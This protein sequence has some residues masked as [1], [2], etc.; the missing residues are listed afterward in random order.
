MRLGYN[1]EGEADSL[2]SSALDTMFASTK[3][4]KV[5]NK[6]GRMSMN[7][8]MAAGLDALRLEEEGEEMGGFGGANPLMASNPLMGG[9]GGKGIGGR[10]K[11]GKG[12]VG[13]TFAVKPGLPPPHKAGGLNVAVVD[14]ANAEQGRIKMLG[15]LDSLLHEDATNPGRSLSR[16][17]PTQRVPAPHS[18]GAPVFVNPNRDILLLFYKK[19]EPSRM[20]SVDSILKAWQTD[21]MP[22]KKALEKKYGAAPALLSQERI[23]KMERDMLDNHGGHNTMRQAHAASI[24]VDYGP[25]A[26][27]GFVDG[28]RHAVI[29]H[30]VAAAPGS[31]SI[32]KDAMSASSNAMPMS[33]KWEPA[34][35]TEAELEAVMRT[36]ILG[37]EG[38]TAGLCTS[39]AHQLPQLQQHVRVEARRKARYGADV[40]SEQKAENGA[41]EGGVDGPHATEQ[42]MI[43]TVRLWRAVQHYRTLFERPADETAQDRIDTAQHI[44]D[45]YMEHAH[46]RWLTS[47]QELAEAADITRRSPYWAESASHKRRHERE[48]R[49]QAKAGTN[50]HA[51][52]DPPPVPPLTL[53]DE[54]QVA[55]TQALVTSFHELLRRMAFDVIKPKR[56]AK[57]A[58]GQKANVAG[59]D[60]LITDNKS[61]GQQ[62]R[63]SFSGGLLAAGAQSMDPSAAVL[64]LQD[65]RTHNQKSYQLML[66][67]RLECSSTNPQ[68]LRLVFQH[69]KKYK[70]GA[71]A[72]DFTL[73]FTCS[74]ER[75]VFC[76]LANLLAPHVQVAEGGLKWEAPMHFMNEADPTAKEKALTAVRGPPPAAG[77]ATSKSKDQG[78]FDAPVKKA[79]GASQG[80][81]VYTVQIHSGGFLHS[82]CMIL[83]GATGLLM[84]E[85]EPA[86][87][88]T[89]HG[90]TQTDGYHVSKLRVSFSQTNSKKLS[91]WQSI[92][93]N[94][95]DVQRLVMAVFPNPKLRTHFGGCLRDMRSR[96]STGVGFGGMIRHSKIPHLPA[97]AAADLLS[98]QRTTLNQ[99]HVGD[100][101]L[102]IHCATWNVGDSSPPSN[103]P[104]K[105]KKK[106]KKKDKK[107]KKDKKDKKKR[108]Q[109][110]MMQ[111]MS[112]SM[113]SVHTSMST[114]SVSPGGGGTRSL[115]ALSTDSA[116]G[117]SAGGE[118]GDM[119]GDMQQPSVDSLNLGDGMLVEEEEGDE[120][121]SDDDDEDQ[122]PLASLGSMPTPT[123]ADLASQYGSSARQPAV[124]FADGSKSNSS[125]TLSM[126]SMASSASG[127]DTN[128]APKSP[129]S[130]WLPELQHDIYAIALQECPHKRAWVNALMT[131]LGASPTPEELKKKGSDWVPEYALLSSVSLTNPSEIHLVIIIRSSLLP[132]VS[133]L[134]TST[135]ATGIDVGLTTLG[136]KGSAG[137]GFVFDEST[138]LAFVCSHLAARATRLKQRA[139]NYADSVSGLRLGGAHNAGGSGGS[140]DFLHQFDHVFWMGD[141]NYRVDLGH[142][143]TESEFNQCLD[144]IHNKKAE[145][146]C[147]LLDHDQLRGEM[148]LQQAFP[149]ALGFREAPVVWPPTYRMMKG[150]DPHAYSQK[151]FQNPSYTD[152]VLWRSAASARMNVRHISATP[153]DENLEAYAFE[154]ERLRSVSEVARTRGVSNAAVAKKK[155]D[156]AAA[157]S[158]CAQFELNDSDHR[159]V[160]KSFGVTPQ[161]ALQLD[162]ADRQVLLL[163]EAHLSFSSV[164]LLMPR[165]LKEE[166]KR[167]KD[168]E[169][170]ESL[171]GLHRDERTRSK[172]NLESMKDAGIE[173]A[174][175]T[176]EAV[177]LSFMG[178]CQVEQALFSEVAPE[179]DP[180]AGRKAE[181]EDGL[182]ELIAQHAA[183]ESALVTEV[184]RMFAEP[185]PH[186]KV[187]QEEDGAIPEDEAMAAGGDSANAAVEQEQIPTEDEFVRQGIGY[188]ATGS[189]INVGTRSLLSFRHGR[190]VLLSETTDEDGQHEE[191]RMPIEGAGVALQLLGHAMPAD[192]L[193]ELLDEVLDAEVEA[194]ASRQQRAN[195]LS[196]IRM[197]A[198]KARISKLRRHKNGVRDRDERHFISY[199][200]FLTL[201]QRVAHGLRGVYNAAAVHPGHV[202]QTDELGNQVRFTDSKAV[203]ERVR[204][205][206]DMSKGDKEEVQA[207]RQS[208]RQGIQEHKQSRAEGGDSTLQVSYQ[209]QSLPV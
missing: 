172:S 75:S 98:A 24:D 2:P 187:E 162:A 56:G 5:G 119:H 71:P 148:E 129:L 125:S 208:F 154:E 51:H 76:L 26:E 10:G 153:E 59:T 186:E 25:A 67:L 194:E 203:M 128:A 174:A 160:S 144:L 53:F 173:K 7:I 159:P 32:K 151:K 19:H 49:L 21:I 152:R 39:F 61:G 199:E 102:R 109:G 132:R 38:E 1:S 33:R 48:E 8:S 146:V 107:G 69:Q 95:I 189:Y 177:A 87:G 20:A 99:N 200:G 122:E 170:D 91:I 124:S 114:R 209:F 96:D 64:E 92:S 206:T 191:L 29:A 197:K 139:Q 116:G 205:M 62:R 138:R 184:F 57:G 42:N 86:N 175:P 111:R 90:A 6:A 68:E 161:Q 83:D 143:G 110:S 81:M 36:W 115:T 77:A 3:V 183:E 66:L 141:L 167:K 41:G 164:Q 113:G 196:E 47:V 163:G 79:L 50:Q 82:R 15:A 37:A 46:L 103:D 120:S 166:K 201:V 97:Q 171:A 45:H 12:G 72:Q 168:K 70:S 106:K 55:C 84:I 149:T 100:Q 93:D 85:Q 108:A 126:G 60:G 14:K 188:G 54:A 145:G 127:F 23:A 121:M 207:R 40:H 192:W 63:A 52:F 34:T 123:H 156:R 43:T 131:H 44:L 17:A 204:S 35:P 198:K 9:K 179:Q 140:G 117:E 181:S 180:L 142:M 182:H 150:E 155:G 118:S 169:G 136:N 195:R 137:A 133:K 134:A 190:Q 30:A 94:S 88:A 80:R 4:V 101:E 105:K 202:A 130:A 22:L 11:G 157:A 31:N 135:V 193:E 27:A 13:V 112:M 58:K 18:E 185:C 158:Y 16:P 74:I 104:S 176:D 147:K 165:A 73:L 89:T 178:P 65:M 78:G 28:P